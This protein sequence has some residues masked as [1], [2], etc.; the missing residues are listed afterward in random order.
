MIQIETLESEDGTT[1]EEASQ[2]PRRVSLHEADLGSH[3]ISVL[4]L[5]DHVRQVI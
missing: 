1:W 5:M 4:T 2:Y 3:S